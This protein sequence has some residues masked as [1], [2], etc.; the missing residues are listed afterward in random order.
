MHISPEKWMH[1]AFFVALLCAWVS[2]W[3]IGRIWLMRRRDSAI[4]RLM[5]SAI[6]CIPF[7]G[8]L[9]YGAFY[10]PLAENDVKAPVNLD[11]WNGGH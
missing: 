5:W 1:A 10:T 4:R 9:F 2:L 6:V 8:W 7:F 3:L 11:A